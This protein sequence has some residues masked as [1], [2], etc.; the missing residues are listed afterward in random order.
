MRLFC[1]WWSRFL[2]AWIVRTVPAGIT[3]T[4][5]IAQAERAQAGTFVALRTHVVDIDQLPG[6]GTLVGAGFVVGS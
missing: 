3:A 4:A 1:E 2:E 5:Q 6:F